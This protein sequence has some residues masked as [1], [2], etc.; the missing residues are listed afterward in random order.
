MYKSMLTRLWVVAFIAAGALCANGQ[1]SRKSVSGAEVTGSF[2]MNFSG[3]YKKIS[4]DIDILALG[5]GKLRIAMD[6][7]YPF[8]IP[9]NEISV[10]M[11]YLSGEAAIEGDTAVYESDEFGPCTITIKFVKPGTIKVT[12]DGSDADCG[13]GHNV[14]ASGTYLKISSKKPTF[15]NPYQ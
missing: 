7:V 3:K 1:A 15:E 2:R 12:Q 10:N 14:F 9:G 11:G 5:G 8:T 6:L 13:F 4:N